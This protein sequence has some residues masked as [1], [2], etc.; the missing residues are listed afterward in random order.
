LA[1]TDGL[2]ERVIDLI[3]EQTRDDAAALADV[4]SH[5]EPVA[6]ELIESWQSANRDVPQ[7]G[8]P[9]ADRVVL[10]ELEPETVRA[11]L[12]ALQQRDLRQFFT[13]LAA[14]ARKLA[15]AGL[16][17]DRALN[18][19]REY[20]RRAIPGLVHVYPAGPEL[21]TALGA[22][23]NLFSG[24]V[25]LLGAAYVESQ[26]GRAD[27]QTRALVLGQ[28]FAGATH[29]LNNLLAVVL[30][31]MAILIERTRVAEDR[32]E[33]LD[34]QEVAAEGAQ[35]LR[36]LQDFVRG[37]SVQTPVSCDVNRS[38]HDAAE[39][40]RFLWRDQAQTAGIV[41]DVVNDFADVPPALARPAALREAFVIMILN[42]VDALARG[43]LIT[44]RSERRG[45][46]VLAS[47]ILS[48][49]AMETR[50]LQGEDSFFAGSVVALNAAAQIAAEM[51]G[52]FTIDAE[53]GRVKSFTLSLPLAQG[54]GE[55]KEGTLMSSHPADVLLI[56]NEPAVRDAFMRLLGLYGH[57]VTTA[58]SGEQGVAAFKAGKFDVVFTDLGM[59]GMSGWDVAREVKK[60]DPKSLVVLITGWPIDLN[61]QKS[62]EMGVDRV[63]S[64]PMDMPQVLGLIADAVALRG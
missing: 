32:A 25:V 43:G 26:P 55:E 2:M 46:S 52:A 4:A 60:I 5:F 21:E 3:V 10:P 29:A 12:A 63:V 20:Q 31:R 38:M 64:K 11:W 50:R 6:G 18:L 27:A 59:P 1:E 14:W 17:Y 9:S 61:P 19:F 47:V 45:N 16:T 13:A 37:D 53:P 44:L 35:M 24:N 58:E 22:F 57:R 7:A 51:N 42:A 41:I 39:V 56:D 23:D 30:G 48:T 15:Q 36:R 49:R 40:T 54:L 34:I 62:K 8:A 33:L 28:I